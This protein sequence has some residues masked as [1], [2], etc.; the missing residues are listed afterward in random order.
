ML[1]RLLCCYTRLKL[2]HGPRHQRASRKEADHGHQWW[3]FPC[4]S[5]KTISLKT[6]T[7]VEKKLASSFFTVRKRIVTGCWKYWR[8]W[9]WVSDDRAETERE[10][11][12]RNESIRAEPGGGKWIWFNAC[13]SLNSCS[14]GRHNLT[15]GCHGH[16]GPLS[17]RCRLVLMVFRPASNETGNVS[18]IASIQGLLCK[19]M[20]F[21]V[22]LQAEVSSVMKNHRKRLS[23]VGQKLAMIRHELKI[24]TV[25]AFH[26]R[27]IDGPITSDSTGWMDERIW[28]QF[29][30]DRANVVWM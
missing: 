8:P 5:L 19:F 6:C 27:L 13:W 29:Y 20:L 28:L 23:K 26:V 30:H 18:K 17:A 15:S 24:D 4:I 22:N 9:K 1:Q 25:L 16:L 11:V 21:F 10:L 14:S 2:L 3:E 7:F 12:D